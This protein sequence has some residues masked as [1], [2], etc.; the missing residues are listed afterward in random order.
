MSGDG[1]VAVFAVVPAVA[2]RTNTGAPAAAVNLLASWLSVEA[3]IAAEWLPESTPRRSRADRAGTADRPAV[4]VEV[5]EPVLLTDLLDVITRRRPTTPRGW[6]RGRRMPDRRAQSV[7]VQRAETV[8]GAPKRSRVHA[9]P[10]RGGTSPGE[11]LFRDHSW[12]LKPQGRT[13]PSQSS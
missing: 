3:Q 4:E 12:L 10:R 1:P 8:A 2:S 9:Q 5:V 6:N 13:Y 11:N 7:W